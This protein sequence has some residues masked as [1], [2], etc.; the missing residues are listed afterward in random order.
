MK[1]PICEGKTAVLDS[2]TGVDNSIRR[3]RKCLE[4]GLKFTTHE[5]PPKVLLKPMKVCT[6]LHL[7]T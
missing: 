2:R 5:L 4:C 3:R 7:E 6:P 1:C